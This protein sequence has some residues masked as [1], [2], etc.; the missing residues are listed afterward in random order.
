MTQLVPLGPNC[1]LLHLKKRIAL[2]HP[3]S[4]VPLG[5]S[6]AGLVGHIQTISS[7]WATLR[8]ELL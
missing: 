1:D 2:E 4:P 7:L 3:E 5:G 6:V 8:W